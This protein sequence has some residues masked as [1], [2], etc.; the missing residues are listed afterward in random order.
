MAR[1]AHNLAWFSEIDKNDSLVVGKKGVLLGELVNEGFPVPKGFI[2]TANAYYDFIREN[3]LSVKISH[4]LSTANFDSPKSL[5]QVSKH[6]QSVILNAN[7]PEELVKEILSAYKKLGGVLKEL[8][9][10]IEFV[11]TND[12]QNLNS[13]KSLSNIKGDAVLINKIKFVWSQAYSPKYLIKRQESGQDNL[14]VG[15]A[16]IVQEKLKDL[17]TGQIITY[18]IKNDDKSKIVID[19][20]IVIRKSDLEIINK[21][22]TEISDKNIKKLSELALELEK[23]LYFPQ[24]ITFGIIKDKPYILDT[25]PLTFISENDSEF[26]TEK[27]IQI[28]YLEAQPAAA[29][30]AAGPL[31]YV[32]SEKEIN[33]VMPGDVIVLSE[34][35]P[36]FLPAIKKASGVITLNGGRDS[37]AAE[38][39][40][41]FGIP[42]IANAKDLLKNLSA[43]NVVTVNGLKGEVY[44]GGFKKTGET[45][46]N[47]KLLKTATKIYV[48][49]SN[50]D[51]SESISKLNV[52]GVNPFTSEFIIKKI[53]IHPK[54]MIRD[55]EKEVF[56]DKLSKA[57][58]KVCKAFEEKPVVYRFS[59][60]NSDEYRNLAGGKD[61]ELLEPNPNLGFRGA[62]R[63]LHDPE[64]FKMEL[65]A[66]KRAR[67]EGFTNL[68]VSIPFARTSQELANVKKI[69]NNF[70]LQRSSNF[71]I[72]L[73]LETPS[74]VIMLEKFLETG[75]DG[76]SINLN[77]LAMLT[78][79]TDRENFEVSAEFS[80]LEP[81]ILWS[82]E[83][84]ISICQKN[85][86][87]TSLYG[88]G[89]SENSELV[90]KLIS[91][92]IDSLSVL[93]DSIDHTRRL[94]FQTEKNLLLK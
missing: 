61:F 6:I 87:A 60:L 89:I 28:N 71:N 11:L 22:K 57:L 91:W 75:I 83:H 7:L 85:K 67:E 46:Y 26:K 77:A 62:F 27:N 66:V 1:T 37:Y 64:S 4:L 79:G 18:D 58:E 3:N 54:K 14:K 13:L 81:S 36:N 70:G 55:E 84:V 39:A 82:L 48:S 45:T 49:L 53:G 12:N 76:V 51:S 29:G 20:N 78:I 93:P 25:K 8:S 5:E 43:G 42:A 68:S 88:L 41:K 86:I 69:I 73:T 34:S 65:E 35:S 50:P 23:F 16:I 30:I 10:S 15:V 94:T 40:R 92:G 80:V 59:D 38:T 56:I 52:D 72:W 17:D 32:L 24:E 63:Y 33:K 90:K 19:E 47:N 31:R 2:I 74:N 9:V 44:K 21:N